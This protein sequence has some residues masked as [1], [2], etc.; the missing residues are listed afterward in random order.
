MSHSVEPVLPGSAPAQRSSKGLKPA[1]PARPA[2]LP[3][4]L[5][6]QPDAVE[7]EARTPPRIA[8]ATLYLVIAL[9]I[10]AVIWATLASVDKI[11]TAPGK[12][13]TTNPNL[14]V[15]PLE[16]SVIR[17][18]RVAVGDVVHKGEVLAT[19]D[20]TFSQ[21]DVSELRQRIATLDSEIS[22]LEAELNNRDFMAS[23]GATP[24]DL[25]Q[26]RLFVER[27]V[28]YEASLRKLDEQIAR[29]EATLE[30]TQS[31]ERY[32]ARRLA[33]LNEVESM[34][35]DLYGNQ[36]GSR[37]N[38]LQA[39]DARLEVESSVAH[40]QGSRIELVHELAKLQSE[41]EAFIKEF[42]RTALEQLVQDRSKRDSAADELEKADLRRHMVTMTAPADAVYSRSRTV[43]SA[44]LCGRPR[45]FSCLFR[46]TKS[47]RPKW[48]LPE[49]M[50]AKLPLA[51]KRGSSSMP[52]L[53]RSTERPLGWFV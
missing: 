26:A 48:T 35:Q 44:R 13:I 12:L 49:R 11:V 53:S 29:T 34:R 14:V 17:D 4:L 50:L 40:L 37:L 51:R 16:T 41:R 42:R 38:V 27:K 6:F 7:I 25:L 2:C 9:I 30:T 8:H 23:P 20:P 5:E 28:Y 32:A 39:R 18:I 47:S 19:L 21:S 24:N 36:V 52:F 3:L 46:E 45:P 1:R 10:T 31:E 33:T 22:R 43:R 15:Q